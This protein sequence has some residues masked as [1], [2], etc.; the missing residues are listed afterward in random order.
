MGS[1]VKRRERQPKGGGEATKICQVSHMPGLVQV[2]CTKYGTSSDVLRNSGRLGLL[3]SF[4]TQ[5]S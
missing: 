3:F 2:T 5:E 1:R 4:Y